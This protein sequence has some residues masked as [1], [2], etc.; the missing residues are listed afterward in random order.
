MPNEDSNQHAYSRSLIKLST[1]RILD[2]QGSK[3]IGLDNEVSGH[4]EQMGTEANL[5]SGVHVRGCV[6]SRCGS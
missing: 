2:S 6:F 3:I 1:G 4:T 5:S